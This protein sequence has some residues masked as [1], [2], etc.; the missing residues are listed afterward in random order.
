MIWSYITSESVSSTNSRKANDFRLIFCG[1]SSDLREAKQACEST[2]TNPAFCLCKRI[3]SHATSLKKEC[4]S[5]DGFSDF[6]K[7]W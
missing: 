4:F 1:L 6:C 7:C 2:L 5:S 3:R